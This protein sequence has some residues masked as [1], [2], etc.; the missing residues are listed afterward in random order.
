MSDEI[1]LPLAPLMP[2]IPGDP[3]ELNLDNRHALYEVDQSSYNVAVM[4]SYTVPWISLSLVLLFLIAAPF[5][6]YIIKG[7]NQ[8]RQGPSFHTLLERIKALQKTSLPPK[9]L[10]FE[11]A[12]LFKMGFE[13]GSAMTYRDIL[14]HL[15]DRFSLA[16]LEEFKMQ[17]NILEK[18][19]FQQNSPLL[20]KVNE[21]IEDV[22]QLITK[23]MV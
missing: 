5:L 12:R 18:M 3:L 22:E 11:T 17:F 9:E 21:T 13:N 15:K 1:S 16:E 7:M 10:I 4:Q 19:Q 8:E 23:S 2:L 6:L 14:E 20:S